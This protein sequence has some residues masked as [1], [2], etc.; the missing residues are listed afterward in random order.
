M[1]QTCADRILR[2][3]TVLARYIERYGLTDEAREVFMPRPMKTENTVATAERD[4]DPG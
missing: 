1:C 3:E 2:L 4:R